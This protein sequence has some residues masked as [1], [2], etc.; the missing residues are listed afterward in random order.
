MVTGG[1]DTDG[2]LD[3]EHRIGVERTRD[4]VAG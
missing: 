3:I 1:R 2:I 4:E